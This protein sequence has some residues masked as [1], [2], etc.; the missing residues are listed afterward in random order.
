MKNL[1]VGAMLVPEWRPRFRPDIDHGDDVAGRGLQLLHRPG[2]VDEEVHF[3]ARKPSSA[4][5]TVVGG[6][7]ANYKT[8]SEAQSAMKTTKVCTTN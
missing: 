1:L 4:S 6:D 5:M 7:G 2:R 3:H 8:E